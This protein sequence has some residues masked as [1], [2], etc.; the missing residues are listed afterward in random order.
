LKAKIEV[1]DALRAYPKTDEASC[2]NDMIREPAFSLDCGTLCCGSTELAE[3]R[4]TCPTFGDSTRTKA[5][6]ERAAVQR[7]FG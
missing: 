4:F 2:S 6:A 1:R 7:V 5:A 3:V